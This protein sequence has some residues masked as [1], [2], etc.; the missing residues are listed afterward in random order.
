MYGDTSLAADKILNSLEPRQCRIKSWVVVVMRKDA[1]LI[2]SSK[3]WCVKV[4]LRELG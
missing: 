1:E 2:V 3:I 4:F